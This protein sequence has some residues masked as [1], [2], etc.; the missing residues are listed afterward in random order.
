MG[1]RRGSLFY[2]HVGLKNCV[3]GEFS[4]RID[5][6][7]TKGRKTFCASTSIGIKTGGLIMKVCCMINWTN[8]PNCDICF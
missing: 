4:E 2:D 1:P 6:K 7:I 8:L 3:N 5:E